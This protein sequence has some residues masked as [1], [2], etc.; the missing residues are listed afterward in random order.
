MPK[1]D[2]FLNYSRKSFTGSNFTAV[3]PST[4]STKKRKNLFSKLRNK[5]VQ[6]TGFKFKSYF[7]S[8]ITG[9]SFL[10]VLVPQNDK[11]S[12]EFIER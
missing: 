12:S 1:M 5:H 11:W 3:L 7:D 4:I 9:E 8:C 10:P 2:M 6:K